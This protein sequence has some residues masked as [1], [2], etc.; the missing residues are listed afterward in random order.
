VA[1][2]I[3]SLAVELHISRY[4]RLFTHWWWIKFCVHVHTHTHTNTH[5]HIHK[6][7]FV[8]SNQGKFSKCTATYQWVDLPLGLYAM[9]TTTGSPRCLLIVLKL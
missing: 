4:Y 3:L 9:K 8:A 2:I 5:I 7:R 1:S 6:F